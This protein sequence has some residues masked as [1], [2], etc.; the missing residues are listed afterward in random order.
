M[1]TVSFHHLNFCD[2]FLG[3]FLLLLFL[4]IPWNHIPFAKLFIF[5]VL[6]KSISDTYF[7]NRMSF[8]EL[9]WKKNWCF[10]VKTK[11]SLNVWKQLLCKSNGM[12]FI[13]GGIIIIIINKM[14]SNRRKKTFHCIQIA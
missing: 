13:V 1:I 9:R 6:A 5:F 11:L 12:I 4:F 10:D 3:R 8:R 7:N 2:L 14:E